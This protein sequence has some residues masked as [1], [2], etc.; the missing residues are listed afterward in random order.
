MFNDRDDAARQLAARLANHKGQNPLIL[1]IPRGAVS[2]GKT[3]AKL[4]DGELDVVLVRK[5]RAPHSPETA[6]GSVD[7]HGWTYL[8]PHAALM[9]ADPDHIAREKHTQLQTLQA[10]RKRYSPIRP[11][12]SPSARV[13]IVVDDGLAT[14]ATMTTVWPPAPP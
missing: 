1:A 8:S 7:E 10:R 6:I 11:P 5:L 14:G 12:I 4:L 13:V 3:L 2:M 9:G